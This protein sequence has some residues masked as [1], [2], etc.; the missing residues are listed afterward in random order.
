MQGSI[1]EPQGF[2]ALDVSGATTQIDDFIKD[3]WPPEGVIQESVTRVSLASTPPGQPP[4]LNRNGRAS[5]G[6]DPL[7]TYYFCH[8]LVADPRFAALVASHRYI[9]LVGALEFADVNGVFWP[10]KSTWG[11]RASIHDETVKRAVRGAERMGLIARESH[12]RPNGRQGSNTYRFDAALVAAASA[13]AGF[14]Q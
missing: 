10:R 7:W 8:R 5:E 1:T 14:G 2:L 9:L 12:A 4:K 6:R 3:G 11:Q 13:D